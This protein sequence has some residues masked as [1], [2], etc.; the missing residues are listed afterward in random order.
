M[1]D[2]QAQKMIDLLVDIKSILKNIKK[3]VNQY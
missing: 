1:T 3:K 2:E